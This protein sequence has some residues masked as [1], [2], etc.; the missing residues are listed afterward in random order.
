MGGHGGLNILP[1]KSWNVYGAK[2]RARVQRDEEHARL[3]A[4]A[5]ADEARDE[6]RDARWRA[7]RESGSRSRDEHVN[8][9]EAEE[10]AARRVEGRRREDA[11]TREDAGDAFGGRGVG[12][13]AVKPWYARA[14][15]E[16]VAEEQ[17]H[18]S[19][20][21]RARRRREEKEALREETRRERLAS[22]EGGSSVE[23]SRGTNRREKKAKRRSKREKRRRDAIDDDGDEIYRL[24]RERLEREGKEAERERALLERDERV[25]D[26]YHHD[27]RGRR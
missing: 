20:P 21:A 13:N 5:K 17:Q 3:E 8:L 11:G 16:H 12:R 27:E 25:V 15:G 23:A 4:E 14:Q 18:A 19:L 7:L 10:R 9:F 6:A 26:R 22:A 2:Q 24:R 1:Q